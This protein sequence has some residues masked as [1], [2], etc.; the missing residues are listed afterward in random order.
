[1]PSSYAGYGY[2]QQNSGGGLWDSINKSLGLNDDIVTGTDSIFGDTGTIGGMASIGTGLY[3]M[4]LGNKQM[5]LLEDQLAMNRE[6]WD[7]SKQELQHMQ[8]TR[9]AITKQFAGN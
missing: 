1:M 5:G 9:A 6:K 2:N 4:Y 3:G 8:G 7:M